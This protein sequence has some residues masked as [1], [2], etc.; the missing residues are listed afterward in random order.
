MIPAVALTEN[1][2]VAVIAVLIVV[3]NEEILTGDVPLISIVK[4]Y[5]I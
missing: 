2:A 5:K 3:K 1:V 4:R